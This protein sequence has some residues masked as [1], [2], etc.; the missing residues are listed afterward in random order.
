MKEIFSF[1]LILLNSCPPSPH[2]IKVDNSP[3]NITAGEDH[4]NDD[5]NH[6]NSLV[7]LL[8]GVGLDDASDGDSDEPVDVTVDRTEDQKRDE[9]HHH[10]VGNENIVSTVSEAF[11]K[12]SWTNRYFAGRF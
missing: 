11:S 6:C 4:N 8:P 3:G 7:P 9:H 2:L 10:K 5:E 12:L 1:F